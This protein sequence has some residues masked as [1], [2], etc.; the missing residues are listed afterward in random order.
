M[1]KKKLTTRVND[2]QVAFNVLDA[3]KNLDEIKNY[4]FISVVDIAVTKRLNVVEAK[5]RSELL[6]FNSLKKRILQ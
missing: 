4:N 5:K 2:Q 3:M 1:C 6:T